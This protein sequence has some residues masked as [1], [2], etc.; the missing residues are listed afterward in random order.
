MIRI[1]LSVDENVKEVLL[2]IT[3][4]NI[5]DTF[6][7]L[8]NGIDVTSPLKKSFHVVINGE[9]TQDW[10]T[11]NVKETD[12]ILITPKLMGGDNA[13]RDLARLLIVVAAVVTG[14]K[15]AALLPTFTGS[16]YVA[17]SITALA[18]YLGAQLAFTAFPPI[19]LDTTAGGSIERSQ[20]FAFTG[21]SNRA[22]Q[23]GFVPKVYG[24]H[25]VFPY[26]AATP[27]IELGVIE[28]KQV[29]YLH[30]IY[31][32]GLGPNLVG[33]IRIGD[34]PIFDFEDVVYNL[35]DL[36]KPSVNEGNWDEP[37]VND[38]EYYKGDVSVESVGV[39]LS[40]NEV[41]AGNPA[42]YEVIRNSALNSNNDRAEVSVNGVFANGLNSIS[43]SG[44][45]GFSRVNFRVEFALLSA[46]DTWYRFNDLNHVE[47]FY[48]S[49]NPQSING[50]LVADQRGL[51][52]ENTSESSLSSYSF[53]SVINQWIIG[54]EIRDEVYR[55]IYR[56]QLGFPN[57]S[58]TAS[59]TSFQNV[60]ITIY[61]RLYSGKINRVLL[62]N[63]VSKTLVVNPLGD[64][65]N[66][67]TYGL[68]NVRRGFVIGEFTYTVYRLSSNTSN[69]KI[70]VPQNNV[71]ISSDITFQVADLG[72]AFIQ[73]TLNEPY[74][75]NFKFTPRVKG[76]YRIKVTRE[77][78]VNQHSFRVAN[79]MTI[80]S[81]QTRLDRAPIVTDKRHTFLE[82]KIRAT[83]QL[84]GNIQNLS[85]VLTSILERYNGTTWVKEPSNNPAWIYADILTG[86]VN[87]KALPKSRLD[88]PSLLEWEEFC[89]EIPETDT[90]FLQELPRFGLNF[91]FDFEA[92][93]HQLM[94]QVTS[95]AQASFNIVDGKYGVLIDRR[96]TVPVQV[97]TPRNSSNFSSTKIFAKLFDAV[98]V[99]F[100]D[101]ANGYE[102]A[103]LTVYADGFDELTAV[104]IEE[105]QAFGCTNFEQAFRYGRFLLAQNK[106]RQE[107]Y[108]IEVDF[109]YLVCLRGDYVR[110]AQDVARLGG[111][112][113][114]VKSVSGNE[115]TIDEGLTT[116][117]LKDYSYTVRRV[118]GIYDGDVT[119]FISADTIEL[120]GPMPNVGDLIIVG[121]KDFVYYDCIVKA[122]EP[123]SDLRAR[124]TL[125][126]KADPI[127]DAELGGPIPDYNPGIATTQ[128]SNDIPPPEVV[129]LAVVANDWRCVAGGY[130]Y[131]VRL[132]WDVPV[133]AAFDIFEVYVDNGNGF[134]FVSFTKAS[135]FE[136]T[137]NQNQ[138]GVEHRFKVLAV[139]AT[140]VK[141]DLGE[142]SAVVATPTR[143]VSPPSDVTSLGID[144]TGEVLQLAWS[145]IPDCDVAD[146]L[147]RYS[148]DI[149]GMWNSSVPLLRVSR[150]TTLASAQ[151]RTGV[152]LIK[153]VDWNGNESANETR[154]ITTIPNLFNLNIIEETSD[155][156][157]LLGSMDRVMNF[158]NTLM[159][160]EEV[161]GTP[162]V[163]QYFSEGYYY[164]E[165]LLDLG[166][167][168]TV[169]LQALITAE[170]YTPFDVI[171]NWTTLEDI[172]TLVTAGS[173]DW[174]VEIEYRTSESFITMDTWD[175]L[176]DVETLTLGVP[177]NWSPWRKITAI[178]DATGRIFQFR[179]RL[180][181]NR[182]SVTPR[183][184][185]AVVRADMPDR[186]D[187][188]NNVLVPDTGL[189]INYTPGFYGPVGGPNIQVSI[190]NAEAGDYWEITNR[191]V[192]SFDIQFFNINGDPVARNADFR[193]KGYGRKSLSVI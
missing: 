128:L 41:N 159:L 184:F 28:G 59:I 38:F 84:N 105:I 22:N 90:P 63:I 121:E 178:T 16:T 89:N 162:D 164:F 158:G 193:I 125:I 112:A 91:V 33:D 32:F 14:G 122:I 69:Y 43:S 163:T 37:L 123:I 140:G 96:K 97:F 107:V 19:P 15:A 151:A 172:D 53:L 98:T 182:S 36:N 79:D 170:G 136:F 104:D 6:Y 23:F 152:Y 114:R 86:Q 49:E 46:P 31:D 34:T 160:Q 133:G 58:N 66:A 67:W 131:Y 165:S 95:A 88:L 13:S 93:A 7:D 62:G 126:E 175:T 77:S 102:S 116:D 179:V 189:T 137:V 138:L 167:I 80:T 127:H 48:Y 113:A 27:Y 190:D 94:T 87:K 8:S 168:F 147:I 85:A 24:T 1:K 188:I 51:I 92:T 56:A 26:I 119:S 146:Y 47:S 111:V 118:D 72:Q 64:G 54:G 2:P 3:R 81:I 110:I 124:L 185:D 75:F 180:I 109:E 120:D 11:V 161:S 142:V 5:A 68:T 139:S 130:Q 61:N 30:A 25:R 82:L 108:T 106:L 100:S 29:Q 171:S 45:L 71:V 186:D 76:Q 132:D 78:E 44:A 83:N 153:A 141:L 9:I 117:P 177:D 149:N 173:S 181:S 40:R 174:D 103:E 101:A 115:I 135:E 150:D 17:A 192:D 60:D 187:S 154:A 50:R 52:I 10:E 129:D 143:K 145:P 18:G 134:D 169:R 70:V 157:T 191:T 39:L 73:Q 176:A 65:R 12:D 99:K 55:P 35:V 57:G 148:P 21:Q 144:I 20:S 42:N 4:G 74:Y 155:F 156:P 183:I 166:E